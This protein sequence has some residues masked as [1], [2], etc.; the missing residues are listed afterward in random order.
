MTCEVFERSGSLP[1]LPPVVGLR[2][3]P[4]PIPE[5]GY[6]VARFSVER[7]NGYSVE[8]G[9]VLAEVFTAFVGRGP[10]T[11]EFFAEALPVGVEPDADTAPVRRCEWTEHGWGKWHRG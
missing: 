4:P 6:A 1:G 9:P 11:H 10:T 5:A 3:P 7:G 2:L 8:H